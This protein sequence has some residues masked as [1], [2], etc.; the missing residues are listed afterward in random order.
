MRIGQLILSI[1]A[2]LLVLPFA[3]DAQ[4]GPELPP[5]DPGAFIGVP[6][7]QVEVIPLAEPVVDDDIPL[8]EP[9]TPDPVVRGPSPFTPVTPMTT[10]LPVDQNQT[11]IAI[12]GY[13][14][15]SETKPPTEM[16]MRTSVF[17]EQMAALLQANIPVISMQDFLE[18][19][20]GPRQQPP[21]CVMIT[22]DD[23]CKSVYTDAF[24]ILKE[25]GFP[26]TLYL[27]T[28]FLTGQGSSLSLAQVREMMRNGAAV[29]SHS[30][31][32]LYPSAWKKNQRQSPEHY[33]EVIGKEIGGSKEWLEQNLFTRI[34]SYCYPGGYHTEEMI[35]ALPSFGYSFAVT[36][37]PKKVV[38]DTDNWQ[39]PRYMVYGTNP[40]TF[41]RAV[42]FTKSTAPNSVVEDAP[43]GMIASSLPVPIYA[44][45][46]AANT[47]VA[48]NT[49]V[50]SI[51]LPDAGNISASSL[52]MR[53]AGFG[54]VPASLIEG[55]TTLAWK[56]NRP[57][58]T[59]SVRVEVSWKNVATNSKEKVEWAFGVKSKATA[60]LQPAN[61]VK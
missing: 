36:V 23:G 44:V 53:V 43:G 38:H 20:H 32:H 56:P 1:S 19:K 5:L 50:I 59:D 22:I 15:F 28:N 29:G 49:P 41:K 2:G 45:E 30:T 11:Q 39:V 35:E 7:P 47:I 37:I 26:F 13:H 17:R 3:S 40:Q 58:R 46:P 24:P 48:G 14:D 4:P 55:T 61:L 51:Q 52:E 34:S 16:R 9:V 21:Y 18:W 10:M 31:S 12:L 60:I 33:R 54:K 57:I 27:Y 6:T 8:A 25:M 42:T